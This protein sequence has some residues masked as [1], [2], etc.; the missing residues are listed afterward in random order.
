[1]IAQLLQHH[2]VNSAFAPKAV[3][4]NESLRKL[5]PKRHGVESSFASRTVRANDRAHHITPAWG[6]RQILVWLL[7]ESAWQLAVSTLESKWQHV[8]PRVARLAGAES[9]RLLTGLRRQVADAQD[10]IVESREACIQTLKETRH[11]IVNGRVLN[12]DEFWSGR[13]SAPDTVIF[14]HAQSMDIRNLPD[15]FEKLEERVSAMT[16]AINQEIQVVI[17]SVQ[18]ED[19]K[20]MKRQTEWMVALALLAAI[21][22]PMTLVTGIFGMNISEINADKTFPTRWAAVK[23]WGI[24]FGATIGCILLYAMLRRPLKWLM[25]LRVVAK[26]KAMDIEALKE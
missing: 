5:R 18:V 19:A 9:F 25:S 13:P 7:T 8:R 2:T 3:P 24:V 22:L 14:R 1:M 4:V 20:T 10:L 6:N 26:R 21:Y 23:A 12:A 11:W 15:S 17:G 16:R